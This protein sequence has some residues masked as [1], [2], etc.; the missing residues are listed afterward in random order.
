MSTKGYVN[1]G[2]LKTEIR[3]LCKSFGLD[4]VEVRFE[5]DRKG[6][7]VVHGLGVVDLQER[8]DVDPTEESN[9]VSWG[10]N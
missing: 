1:M 10:D 6:V 3:K 4:K 7:T 9:A 8:L 2:A 5:D